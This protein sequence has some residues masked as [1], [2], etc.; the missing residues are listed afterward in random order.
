MHRHVHSIW[1]KVAKIHALYESLQWIS[2]HYKKQ[3]TN[4]VNYETMQQINMRTSVENQ[5]LKSP[6]VCVCKRSPFSVWK[7]LNLSV[8]AQ[9][10]KVRYRLQFMKDMVGRQTETRAVKRKIKRNKTTVGWHSCTS[11]TY[12]WTYV[13][14]LKHSPT[15]CLH[16]RQATSKFF[17]LTLE[18]KQSYR[19]D[20]MFQA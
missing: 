14:I 6:C 5:S 3:C 20:L 1:N 17:L 18:S 11:C 12:V 7:G 4:S 19:L 9:R 10:G 13:N 16:T 8:Q 2:I 15:Q